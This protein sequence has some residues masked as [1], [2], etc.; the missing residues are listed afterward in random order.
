MLAEDPANK[1]A[2]KP[3]RQFFLLAMP[4]E[5]RRRCLSAIS[6]IKHHHDSGRRRI[7]RRQSTAL[8]WHFVDL[9]WMFV[10]ALAYLMSIARK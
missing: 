5:T 10:V 8:Y 4:V 6:G 9:V 1:L 3:P 2:R 7:R